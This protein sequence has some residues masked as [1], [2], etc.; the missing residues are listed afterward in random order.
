M[1]DMTRVNML[2]RIEA[3]GFED[4]VFLSMDITRRSHLKAKGGLGYSYLLD[5]FVPLMKE[6]GISD[7]FI[8]KML[9]DNPNAFYS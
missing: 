3:E 8:K 4:N 9:K 1:P 6:N 2:K 5:T 7:K